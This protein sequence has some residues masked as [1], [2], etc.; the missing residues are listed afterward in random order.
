[1]ATATKKKSARKTKSR[2]PARKAASKKS[3]SSSY[4][5]NIITDERIKSARKQISSLQKE[6]QD[7]DKK[8]KDGGTVKVTALNN[9]VDAAST[10][11]DVVTN[12]N[13]KTSP[14]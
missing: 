3:A 5:K 6:I 7:L 14:K 4:T 8:L 1:M 10:L 2:G 11:R 9:I 13:N 12:R